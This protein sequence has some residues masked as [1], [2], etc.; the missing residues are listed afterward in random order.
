MGNTMKCELA[1]ELIAL[2]VYG[3]LPDDPAGFAGRLNRLA[4]RGGE[5]EGGG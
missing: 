3:E 1:Q 4:L 5:R 2:S